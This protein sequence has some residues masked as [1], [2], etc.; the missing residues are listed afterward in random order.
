MKKFLKT[1]S[2]FAAVYI[3][4]LCGGG[5]KKDRKTLT[6]FF[7]NGYAGEDLA[8]FAEVYE[9]QTGVKLRFIYGSGEY[10][11]ELEKSLM[12]DSAPDVVI[13]NS[14]R[15]NKFIYENFCGISSVSAAE[16][17]DVLKKSVL[18]DG[19]VYALPFAAEGVGIVYNADVFEKYKKLSLKDSDVQVNG[20]AALQRLASGLDREKNTLGIKSVFAMP[21]EEESAEIA[22]YLLNLPVFFE[23]CEN[24]DFSDAVSA[25][26]NARRLALR[27]SENLRE[28]TKLYFKYIADTP[29]EDTVDAVA[30]G[31]AAMTVADTSHT[32]HLPDN[33]GIM[34]LYMGFDNEY[35]LDISTDITQYIAVNK[36]AAESA[37]QTAF[38]F[39]ENLSKNAAVQKAASGVFKKAIPIISGYEPASGIKSAVA[40][41]AL[42]G[43]AESPPFVF[44]AFP[45]DF[46]AS[47]IFS[48]LLKFSAGRESWET[49]ENTIKTLWKEAMENTAGQVLNY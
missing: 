10:K 25:A 36:N 48:D 2:L 37:K 12:S 26:A 27:Y 33:L 31:A 44:K 3:I 24:D 19:A 42:K 7:E 18:K 15:D 49:A 35:A 46:S 9:K 28:F 20:F 13:L 4:A 14:S 47:Y 43:D 16:N 5:C 8:P 23:L 38:R 1:L 39:I 45:K 40:T 30:K 22:E 6:V 29:C 11:E 34:P 32:D 17:A 41:A 21:Q